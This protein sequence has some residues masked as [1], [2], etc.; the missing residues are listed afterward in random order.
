ADM[1][2]FYFDQHNET[3][4]FF[5]INEYENLMNYPNP[6][7]TTTKISYELPTNIEN[8]TI[9]IFSIKGQTIREYPIFNNQSLIFWDGRD[10]YHN[11]VSSGVY[12]YRL[13]S[14]ERVLMSK[15]MILT[16]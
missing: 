4:E 9:G 8:A 7:R 6:F 1:G 3:E 5:V 2:A 14:D 12:F 13:I 15:K 11:Q 10:K 16:R